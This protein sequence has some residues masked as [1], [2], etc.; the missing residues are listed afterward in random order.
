MRTNDTHPDKT[1]NR[2]KPARI[3]LTNG[4]VYDVAHHFVSEREQYVAAYETTRDDGID[5]RIPLSAIRVI[6]TTS[7][8]EGQNGDHASSVGYETLA[9][10]LESQSRRSFFGAD[11]GKH[12]ELVTDGG[13]DEEPPWM[14]DYPNRI[15]KG[16]TV[17][18]PSDDPA[19]VPSTTTVER[20][21]GLSCSASRRVR[22]AD[23]PS[24]NH[25]VVKLLEAARCN[26]C[27]VLLADQYAAKCHPRCGGDADGE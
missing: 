9:E 10:K 18:V 1:G 2:N 19:I 21:G 24:K 5:Y 15:E 16:E 26:S 3:E 23:G 6:D 14:Q 8:V 12:G 20:A 25:Q 27:G 22:L 13:I 17:V 7:D 11:E 4:D